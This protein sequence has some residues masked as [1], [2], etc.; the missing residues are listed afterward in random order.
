MSTNASNNITKLVDE[1][2][3]RDQGAIGDGIVDDTTAITAAL[4]KQGYQM[5]EFKSLNCVLPNKNIQ[6]FLLEVIKQSN[7]PGSASEFVTEVKQIIMNADI[8]QQ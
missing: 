7:F 4:S 8:V 2:S 3:V 5:E 6:Q 1:L